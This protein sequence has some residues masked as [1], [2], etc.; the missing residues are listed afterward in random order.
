MRNSQLQQLLQRSQRLYQ[1]V[2][3]DWHHAALAAV[4]GAKHGRSTYKH[5]LV[6]IVD[7]VASCTSGVLQEPSIANLVPCSNHIP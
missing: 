5:K 2:A 1:V 6:S 3:P 7:D 4:Q